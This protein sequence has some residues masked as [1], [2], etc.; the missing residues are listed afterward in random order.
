MHFK[1]TR[2]RRKGER[3]LANHDMKETSGRVPAI[4]PMNKKVHIFYSIRLEICYVI[5]IF[6]ILSEVLL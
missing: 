6:Q 5:F 1:E 4:N 2:T 3:K